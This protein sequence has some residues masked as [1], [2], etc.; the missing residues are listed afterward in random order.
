[1][2]NIKTPGLLGYQS[3]EHGSNGTVTRVP[4]PMSNLETLLREWAAI[5]PERCEW[6]S[7]GQERFAVAVAD[8]WFP[9]TEFTDAFVKIPVVQ[10]AIQEAIEARGWSWCSGYKVTKIYDLEHYGRVM[11]KETEGTT[12][13][14]ALLAAYI[15]ALK[16]NA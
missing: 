12:P 3:L 15:Q 5:E 14:E 13:A 8:V 9:V 16:A 6:N 1:M 7:D 2:S 11:G 4:D 10:Y